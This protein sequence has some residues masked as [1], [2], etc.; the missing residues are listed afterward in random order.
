M[1]NRYFDEQLRP[2]EKEEQEHH[3]GGE[4]P[5]ATGLEDV[6]DRVGQVCAHTVRAIQPYLTEQYTKCYLGGDDGDDGDNVGVEDNAGCCSGVCWLVGS[7]SV[8][9]CL[10]YT[11]PSP[12]D[13]G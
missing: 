7:S 9:F 3:G 11:S 6:W 4:S 12:R 10:L 2:E 1:T 5:V 8:S 13:R